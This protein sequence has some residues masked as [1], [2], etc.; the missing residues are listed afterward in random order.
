[1]ALPDTIADLSRWYRAD[2]LAL[3]D[4][5]PVATWVDS[6][7]NAANLTAAGAARPTYRATRWNG[8]PGLVFS[9]AQ[10]MSSVAAGGRPTSGVTVFV[11]ASSYKHAAFPQY[12]AWGSGTTQGFN[13]YGNTGADA[14]GVPP[15][16]I[17][18]GTGG[19][20]GDNLATTG[21]R[22]GRGDVCLITA[23]RSGIETWI[24]IDGGDRV[25]DAVG[26][27]NAIDYGA[28]PI[29]LSVGDKG[30]AAGPFKG[31]VHE[32]VIYDRAL[33]PAE[34]LVVEDYLDAKWRVTKARAL[35][36][37]LFNG[38]PN[39]TAYNI[40][41]A[42]TP[43]GRQH[44]RHHGNPVIAPAG[45]GW[46]SNH[47]KDPWLTHDGSQHVAYYAG[48]STAG[49]AYQV[50]RATSPDGI[51]WT[52]HVGNPVI[53]F[54]AAGQ[55]DDA[56]VSFPVVVYDVS[57]PASRRW[58]MWYAGLKTADSLNRIGHAYSAD[59]ITWTKIGQVLDVGA[60]GAWDDTGIISGAI[61]IAA[62]GGAGWLLYGGRQGPSSLPIWQTGIATFSNPEG[63]YTKHPG[64]PVITTVTP[65]ASQT[66][67]AN[68]AAG[69]RIVTIPST[70]PFAVGSPVALIATAAVE[71]HRVA[72]IDS[73]TQ[74]TLEWPTDAAFNTI[75]GAGVRPFPDWTSIIPRRIRLSGATWELAG[76]PFQ[77]AE[78]L[79]ILGGLKLREAAARWTAA[80][81]AGPWVL[82]RTTGHFFMLNDTGRW[83]AVSA[84]NPTPAWATTFSV[85][86]LGFAG[87]PGG[88]VW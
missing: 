30:A 37:A 85:P 4:G 35:E 27:A 28:G 40:G 18:L 32:L 34:V 38:A 26:N 6:S 73:A 56:G 24:Q 82:D 59:G 84:E 69:S 36:L 3:A 22:P 43:D 20:W 64:N 47:V 55:F 86:G 39:G 41:L 16:F 60:G 44:R 11:V 25:T 17:L 7:A 81:V 83:D 50:G 54:G 15:A 68:T 42:W 74:L 12:C 31:I 70:G 77:P 79:A 2:S 72:S 87:D 9:G 29:T 88:G 21:L 8:L 49:G 57:A 33:T 62:G 14:D 46:E 75:D 67:S 48:S 76:T 63:A 61:R 80:A 65:G 45:L 78:D 1:M 19:V 10:V 58:R 23:R 13:L 5:D 51:T 66:L 52:K 71:I 53:A